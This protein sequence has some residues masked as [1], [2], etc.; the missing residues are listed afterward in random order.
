LADDYVAHPGAEVFAMRFTI[1]YYLVLLAAGSGCGPN[2]VA[3]TTTATVT[4]QFDPL[5]APPVVPT[6]NDLAFTGG[7]G[8]HLNIPDQPG[9]SPAQLAFNAYLRSLTGFP[10]GSTVGATFSGAL[11]ATSV[12]VPTATAPGAIVVVDTTAGAAVTGLAVS[13]ASDGKSFSVGNPA[14]FTSGHR[15]AVLVF[16]GSDANGLRGADGKKVIASPTFFFLRS[17]TPLVQRCANPGDASCACP[18]AAL[19][20]ATDTTCH[21]ATQA[22]SDAQARQAE[23]QR[24]AVNQALSQLLPLAAPSR[25]RNDVVLFWSFT[26]TAQPVAEFDPASGE[27]PFP[28][29]A[30]ID[31]MTGNVSL[32]IAANDPAAPLKMQLNTLDGFSVSA[33]ATVTVDTVAGATLDPPTLL[34]GKTAVLLNLDFSA[35]AEAPVYDAAPSFGQVAIIPRLPL[36]GDQVR[37][38]AVV[39]RDVTAGGVPVVPAP[40]TALILQPNPLFDGKH[41]TVSALDDGSAKKLEGLRMA[42]QPLIGLVQ[43]GGI[44]PERIAALWT[45]TTQSI[46]RP[47][48]AADAYPTQSMITTDVTLTKVVQGPDL[49]G[50]PFVANL[51]AVVLGT[52]TSNLIYDPVTRVV[53]FMRTPSTAPAATPAQDRFTVM[54]A[55][56]LPVTIRFWLT[57]PKS[58]PATGAPIVIAQ[59]GLTSWRGDVFSLG[60]D[61]AGGGS[62]T[63]GFDI[64]FHGARTKCSADNQCIGGASGS[65]DTSKG[66]CAT[67]FVPNTARNPGACVLAAFSGDMTN[68]CEPAAS[69]NGYVD[70]ANLFGGRAGGFQYVADAAQLVRVLSATGANSLQA[71]LTAAGLSGALDPGHISFFGHSLGSINGSLFL[72]VDPAPGG[73]NVLSVGGGHVFEIISDGDFHVLVDGLLK[74]LGIMR[75]TS[76]YSQLV[77]TA[78]WALDPVDPFSAARLIR[79]APAF[80]YVFGT[81]NAPKLA[82]V[83]QA[84]MDTVVLPQYEAALNES[85]WGMAGLDAGHNLGANAAGSFVSTYFPAANHGTVLSAMP[86]A[87][88]RVQADT[89]LLSGGVTLPAATP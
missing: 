83:Q 36:E 11:D 20:S 74:Q 32:P 27:L 56:T 84:G 14:R 78:R 34:A 31:Q 2:V 19:A 87:S 73:G 45:F 51:K 86:S 38:A 72:A 69:G 23:P 6:P 33:A 40:A 70:P 65:C 54:P 7:D 82:I 10:P 25:S 26:I 66:A 62:A 81:T 37:Y 77:Q 15:Y 46:A 21:S 57:L 29:D 1:T 48:Q 64:D 50:L 41:S 75:G 89:Y 44:P 24:Q 59:H 88:M 12:T 63:I 3:P 39:T 47:L 13:V 53:K 22:L 5:A 76:A 68:D 79:R 43:T 58:T 28:N 9:Q 55:M 71:K 80:S 61:M 85:L 4:A 16:G 52:F 42:L 49:M 67:G 8:V 60:T 30:L 35:T 18:A 17:P